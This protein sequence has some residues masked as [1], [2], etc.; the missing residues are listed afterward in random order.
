MCEKKSQVSTLQIYLIPKL[1]QYAA[2]SSIDALNFQ[3]SNKNSSR[4][5]IPELQI[6][7][8]SKSKK[9][10]QGYGSR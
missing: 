5:S 9:P 8:S 6:P 2:E 3:D 7:C 4:N 10:K 1:N